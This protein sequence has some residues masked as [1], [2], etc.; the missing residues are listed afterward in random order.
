M[1]LGTTYELTDE[2][3]FAADAEVID[4]EVGSVDPAG[5]GVNP[6]FDGSADQRVASAPLGAGDSHTYRITV[7]TTDGYTSPGAASS[8]VGDGATTVAADL[9]VAMAKSAAGKVGGAVAG[10][11]LSAIGLGGGNDL[12]P[13]ENELDQINQDLIAIENELSAI[14]TTLIQS[15]CNSEAAQAKP[16]IT[17][18]T[19][20]YKLYINIVNNARGVG[21]PDNTPT[22]PTDKTLQDFYD[23]TLG[24]NSDG[25]PVLIDALSSIDAALREGGG[26]VQGIIQ[27]CLD[28][29]LVTPPSDTALG[30]TAYYEQVYDL[31]N[32][33]LVWQVRGLWML[34]E[35]YLYQAQQAVPSKDLPKGVDPS[36]FP[37]CGA[38]Y[39][40]QQATYCGD[41]AG[42]VNNLYEALVDQ[43]KLAGA[44][45][46][47]S[48]VVLKYHDNTQTLFVTSLDDF[49]TAGG[50]GSC[51][52]PLDSRAPCGITRRNYDRA[53]TSDGFPLSYPTLGSG[54]EAF[55]GYDTWRPAAWDE[56]MALLKEA[57]SSQAPYQYLQANGFPYSDNKV[58][59][60]DQTFTSEFLFCC[61]VQP[62]TAT[63]FIDTHFG[64]VYSPAT[65]QGFLRVGSKCTI[66]S[67]NPAGA[68]MLTSENTIVANNRNDWY[69][70]EINPCSQNANVYNPAPGWLNSNS[71]ASNAYQFAW[72]A[73]SLDGMTCLDNWTA[74]GA[75]VS[76]LDATNVAGVL[77]ICGDDFAGWVS[78][79]VPRP[80]TCAVPPTGPYFGVC[81]GAISAVDGSSGGS[82]RLAA[83]AYDC[84]LDG[85][86]DGTG[87]FN[88]ATATDAHSSVSDH[89]CGETPV[90]TNSGGHPTRPTVDPSHVVPPTKSTAPP[91]H[92]VP[93]T[94]FVTSDPTSTPTLPHTGLA[95]AWLAGIALMLLTTGGLLRRASRTR[96][97]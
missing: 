83:S 40:A 63:T 58:L 2:F 54:V 28:P 62:R 68:K 86:E 11:L 45:Y 50:G 21:P 23:A 29:S 66:Q 30:D 26:K 13:L 19:D 12:A 3:A 97:H 88:T 10:E 6:S 17:Q 61:D 96:R 87:L 76:A 16:G 53:G 56:F 43:L 94:T 27:A 24:E 59:V 77:T 22:A 69:T 80:A 85:G 32:Y 67:G 74:S 20:A 8:Q 44:P 18:I 46:S 38:A 14:N 60:F 73:L 33:Y 55:A 79:Q 34:Q 92:V 41:A 71:A 5:I 42:A 4:V 91:S 65:L 37:I 70:V 78:G 72:P 49:T 95:L 1:T 47:N 52:F 36:T 89:G 81:T 51:T 75:T 84:V 15:E 7:T 25:E 64:P 90:P 39:T 48:D 9:M 93:P 82:S 31:I 35:S 57:S